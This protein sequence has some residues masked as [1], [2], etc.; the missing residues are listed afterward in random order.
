M[1][2]LA[3]SCRRA[4]PP[5]VSSSR[6]LETSVR[7][8]WDP[9]RF[10]PDFTISPLE[11]Y[12]SPGMELAF[13][14]VFH[15]DELNNDVRYE[16]IPCEIEGSV[17]LTLTLTGMCVAQ[18]PQS[19]V[20]RFNAAVRQRETKS[21][22]LTNKTPQR[23]YLQPII[24]SEFWTG[25]ESISIEPGQA[26]P[27]EIAY[28]PLTMTNDARHSGTVFFPLPDGSG[29][30]YNLSGTADAPKPSGT[31]NREV[32]CKT[33]YTELL[34]VTNWLKRP[35]RFKVSIEVSKPDSST[36]LKGVDYID[37]PGQMRRDYKLNF[38]AYKEGVT[39][40]RVVFRNEQTQEY[41]Y[42]VVTFKATP[43]GV[44][45]MVDMTTP[46]RQ[47]IT[48]TL[49]LENPLSTPVQLTCSCSSTD[50]IIPHNVVLPATSEG[51]IPIEYL[52]LRVGDQ[53]GK[54]LL[55]S[56]ELGVYQYDLHLVAT[57][58]GPERSMQFKVGLGA[59]QVQTFRFLSFAKAK[60]EYTCRI[61]SLDFTV[62]KTVA[63]PANTG[64]AGIEVCV[65]VTYE[66]SKL[67]DARTTLY[68]SSPTGGE[69]T[70]PLFGHCVPS[71]PQGPFTIKAGT[72]ASIPF[73]NVFAASH[74]FTFT[75]DN[76]A[77]SVK[78]TE[79]IGAKKTFNVQITYKTNTPKVPRMGK[80][81]VTSAVGGSEMAG[82]SWTYYLR[83]VGTLN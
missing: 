35:Q 44:I 49:T 69:Y 19:E 82:V 16:D 27:Y 51:Q 78:P 26:K 72:T 32:P 4:D 83:G 81:V 50:V 57:P 68:L 18:P 52:P 5:A 30:L 1:C 7:F 37:V 61:D 8:K 54:L 14:V 25:P 43:P 64:S 41:L 73:K 12:I 38:Y 59:S 22:T 36:S 21:I 63:A 79:T 34:P 10:A 24:D 76:P 56:A 77:F 48:R 66:P 23:W 65:D 53:T 15:P 67:G 3:L 13:E 20:I 9:K 47:S 45:S 42:Y 40:A 39:N 29:L 55:T 74:S 80:L 33:Q 62:D 60:T 75:V 70:C 11:G 17:P 28:T 58:A 71:K 31:I 6:T 46:V 2:P